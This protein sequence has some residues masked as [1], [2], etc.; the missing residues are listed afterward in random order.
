MVLNS[1]ISHFIV[2][3]RSWSAN[4]GAELYVYGENNGVI[5]DVA[6]N[7]SKPHMNLYTVGF[8]D[9]V[10]QTSQVQLCSVANFDGTSFEK[11]PR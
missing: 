11:V 5:W 2:S 7:D 10:T 3:Y 4:I 8:F 6:S 9:T 1:S